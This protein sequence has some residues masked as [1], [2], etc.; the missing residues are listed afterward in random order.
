MLP[1]ERHEIIL[2]EI[3]RHAAVS[4]RDLTARLGVT[5]ETVRKDIELLASRGMVGQVRGGAVRVQTREAPIGDRAQTNA[6]GKTRISER[7]A[8]IVPDGASVA[9]DMGST[10]LCV[11]QALGESVRD[12]SV[13]T[14]DLR[15]SEAL[16]PRCRE[17]VLLGGRVA[18]AEM[19]A[20]GVE[21]LSN[22][23]K[24][25]TEFAVVSVGGLSARAMFTNFSR[26]AVELHRL[27]FAQAE[28]TLVLVDSSK[29]DVVGQVVLGALPADVEILSD[30]PP[31]DDIAAALADAGASVTVVD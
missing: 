4:I 19:A 2:T 11:A 6:A 5:R 22:L 24:Y 17:L 12:L 30:A 21:V 8:Q 16:A 1:S 10:A 7:V 25:R 20:L 14:N 15:V 26:E 9:I 23:S 18:P 3:R 27:M 31:P 13:V 28:R 29:Y